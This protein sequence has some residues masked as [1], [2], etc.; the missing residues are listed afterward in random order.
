[1]MKEKITAIDQ[2]MDNK[3]FD[4]FPHFTIVLFRVYKRYR[5]MLFHINYQYLCMYA[6]TT[7]SVHGIGGM[8][9]PI[10]L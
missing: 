7:Y 6:K 9:K 2:T 5:E 1:M 4:N 8:N 10:K 3:T